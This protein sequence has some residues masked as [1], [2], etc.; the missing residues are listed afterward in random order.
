LRVA[1]DEHYFVACGGQRLEKKHPEMG[2]KITG[3]PVIGVVQQ[4]A[5]EFF[6]I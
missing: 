1:V 3:D 5:H 4:N 2:H 6:S